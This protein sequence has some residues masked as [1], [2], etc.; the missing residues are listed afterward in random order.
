MTDADKVILGIRIYI[1]P[2]IW[3]QI[4]DHFYMPWQRFTLSEHALVNSLYYW[5]ACEKRM[6]YQCCFYSVVQ[7]WVFTHFPDFKFWP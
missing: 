4:L 2:E 1:N 3:I 5:Q 7:K 6:P